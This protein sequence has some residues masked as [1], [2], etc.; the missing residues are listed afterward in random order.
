MLPPNLQGISQDILY[1]LVSAWAMY[2][3]LSAAL[4][5]WIVQR[6]ERQLQTPWRALGF[7]SLAVSFGLAVTSLFLPKL[8]GLSLVFEVL[9]FATIG[10]GVRREGPLS[11]LRTVPSWYA[12]HPKKRAGFFFAVPATVGML[13]SYIFSGVFIIATLIL[14]T[15]RY[16][17]EQSDRK[18]RWQNLYPLFAYLCFLTRN[19][20]FVI[21]IIFPGA[22][23]S[24]YLAIHAEFAGFV[25]LAIWSW[26]FIRV[27]KGLRTP[28]LLLAIGGLAVMITVL[29]LTALFILF[30]RALIQ[31]S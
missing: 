27:R 9:G 14:Q 30:I 28:V 18:I 21:Y 6:Q 16:I 19:V 5:F 29:A 22:T 3:S 13:T 12:S 26:I 23:L 4:L 11:H 1:L 7:L 24:W 20:L 2:V 8:F 31:Q 10:Y 17:Q 25:F 15:E